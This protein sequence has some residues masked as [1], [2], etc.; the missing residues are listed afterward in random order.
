MSSRQVWHSV[1]KRKI[2]K[3]SSLGN[4]NVKKMLCEEP[5]EDYRG[6][7]CV[8]RESELERGD[9]STKAHSCPGQSVTERGAVS[10]E[11]SSLLNSVS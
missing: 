3:R 8:D 6:L 5:L 10:T 9:M 2:E 7:G 1:S 4:L 11:L